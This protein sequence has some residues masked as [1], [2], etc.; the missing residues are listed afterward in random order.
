[1]Y[2]VAIVI[3]VYNNPQSIAKV[4]DDALKDT[5]LDVIVVD[6]GSTQKVT[7]LLRE[8]SRLHVVEHD[9]NR[10]KGEAILSGAKVA[11]ERGY[12]HF[13]II[14]GDGQHYPKEVAHFFEHIEDESIIIGNRKFE[15]NV[16]ESSKFGRKFSN[17]WIKVETGLALDDTQSG[18]RLYPIS[19]LELPIT[20]ERYD[21]EI[22]VLVRHAWRKRPIKEVDIAVYYPKK[23]ERIS[24]FDKFRDNVRLSLLHTQLTLER[25]LL[26]RGWFWA[27]TTEEAGWVLR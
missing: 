10:G 15:Q 26:L 5:T 9:Q 11:K 19:I 24:H 7:S 27:G 16:P 1:M 4:V 23:E 14:D 17:F 20:R 2:K 22:E 25:Y 21:F 6:D 13:F 8:H 12:S 3:P 18:F